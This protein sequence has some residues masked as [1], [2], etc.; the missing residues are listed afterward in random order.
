VAEMLR[1]IQ[2]ELFLVGAELALGKAP[3]KKITYS[4]V[5]TLESEI[6]KVEEQLPHLANFIIPGGSKTAAMLHLAR[7]VCRRAE[8]SVVSL[9]RKTSI[10]PDII[11]YL[12]RLGDLLFVLARYE[13]KKKHVE[14]VV[15][16][17]K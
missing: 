9:E 6:D 10:N 12:N 8:R 16:R 17:G 4:H 3:Q 11:R 13:N 15:W 14:E 1:K 5:S 2:K 7:T